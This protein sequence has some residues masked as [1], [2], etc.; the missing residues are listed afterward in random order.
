M[1]AEKKVAILVNIIA[2]YRIPLYR[3]IASRFR[4]VVCVSG[5]E[6]NRAIWAGIANE[7]GGIEVRR[8]VGLTVP[9]R[10][11]QES[12]YE[13][14]L[15]HLPFGQLLDLVRIRPDAIL[16]TEMGA[17]TIQAL[18]YGSVTRTPVWVWWGGTMHTERHTGWVRSLVRK[19]VVAWAPRWISYGATSTEYLRMLGVPRASILQ[20][21]NCVDESLYLAA[22]RAAPLNTS[23]S[24]SPLP[25]VAAPRVLYVG[26]MVRLKG[27]DRF[28]EA[29]AR[30]QKEGHEFSILLVG[31][32]PEKG[33][34]ESLA[35]K[36]ELRD[37]R[38][39]AGQ[40]PATMPRIYRDTDLLVFPTCGDVWGLVVNEAMWSG[41]PVIASVYAGCASELLPPE[42]TFD[43]FDIDQFAAILKRAIVN[44][45]PPPDTTPLKRCAE[46]GDAI[47]ADI[48]R[49]LG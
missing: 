49:T 5:T 48:E 45:L 36:L 19:I 29:A 1:S 18:L 21:Q 28:L 16:T 42:Q 34:F 14:K 38:F 11:G 2:P 6:R 46:V 33:A 37:A 47:I 8:T 17:R 10:V 40:P 39:L 13:E 12:V 20:I 9:F 15:L 22:S 3:R 26:R 24:A 44:G 7:L 43:P 23:G 27:V 25:T 30:V 32:G 35:R 41:L 4:T 31:D